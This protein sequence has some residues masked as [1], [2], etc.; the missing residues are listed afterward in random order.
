MKLIP[1]T[2]GL[3]AK[4]DDW[5]YE[6]LIKY[7]WCAHKDHNTHYAERSQTINGKRVYFKMHRVIMNTPKGM[8]V[9]HINSDGIDNQEI[10]M[11]NCTYAENSRNRKS[12]VNSYSKFLGVFYEGKK[13]TYTSKITGITT[14][15]IYYYYTVAI[16]I[17]GKITY[18]GTFKDEITAAKKYN[19]VALIYHGEFAI[20]NKFD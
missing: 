18:I 7:K 2:L 5:H 6:E 1:L 15:K 12:K 11:R 14:N 17:K 16:S 8:V 4:V 13:Y 20:L 10:N 19:E 3:F 9:D